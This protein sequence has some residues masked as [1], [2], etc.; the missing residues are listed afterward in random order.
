MTK[1]L[2]VWKYYRANRRKVNVVFTITFISIILQYALL[3]YIT[4]SVNLGTENQALGLVKAVSLVAL[5][6]PTRE[7]QNSVI[8]LLQQHPAVAQVVPCEDSAIPMSYV[9][10]LMLFLKHPGITPLM[11]TLKLNLIQG[12]LPKPGTREVLLHWR[13]AAH[14]GLKIG[15]CFTEKS[16]EDGPSNYQLSGLLDGKLIMG[17]ADLDRYLQE[18][19]EREEKMTLLVV[20]QPDQLAQVSQYVKR[21]VQNNKLV[22]VSGIMEELFVNSYNDLLRMTNI[23]HLVITGIIA[24]CASFLFYLYFYQRQTE[25]GL[26]EAMG[27]T[28]PQMIGRAFVE[29]LMLNLLGLGGALGISILCGWGLNHFFLHVRGGDL[30]LWEPGYL[31]KLLS[32]PVLVTFCSLAPVWRLLK[33]VDPI[34]IIE[35][36]GGNAK[37][38]R[39]KPLSN[40]QYFRNNHRPAGAVLMVVLLSSILQGGLLSYTT[41]ML[42]LEQRCELEPWAQ[43]T[44]TGYVKPTPVKLGHLRQSLGKHPA[45][46]KV[47]PYLRSTNEIHGVGITTFPI[48][49]LDAHEI[50]STLGGLN[51]KL[52]KGRLPTASSY[53][54]VMHWQLAANWG[55]K[56]GDQ[57]QTS[58][59]RLVGIV[60]GKPLLGLANL[61]QLVRVQHRAKG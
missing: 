21:L 28:R 59:Y 6:N 13:I 9:G 11:Q 54:V 7:K 27:H 12:R 34:L 25:F 39:V 19:Q 50:P 43:I 23:I 29:I 3:V 31:F 45:I 4:S 37:V 42:R 58:K 2:S 17:F 30:V 24:I 49:Y 18:K 55:I 44:Y 60:E 8:K 15:D 47:L 16:S 40:W 14:K 46:A 33:R 1:P 57:V 20:P 51:L 48:L 56:I 52:V 53:E 10:G 36:A 35:R 61:E 5:V 38:E 26:L 41:S 32:T 22:S